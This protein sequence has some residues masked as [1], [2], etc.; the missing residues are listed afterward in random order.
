MTD[1]SGICE[2]CR[3]VEIRACAETTFYSLWRQ[4]L[5]YIRRAKPMTD[6]CIT[7]KENSALIV[8]SANLTTDRLTEVSIACVQVCTVSVLKFHCYTGNTE[9]Y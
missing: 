5:P 7:C 8:R 6:L 4:Y 9:S 1:L 3:E 2:S